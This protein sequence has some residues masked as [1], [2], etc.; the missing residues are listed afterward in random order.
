MR[1]MAHFNTSRSIV[2]FASKYQSLNL[3]LPVDCRITN[4]ATSTSTATSTLTPNFTR[5]TTDK[6]VK[7]KKVV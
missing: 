1:E 6:V 7:Q 3:C 4:Q 5:K 2:F